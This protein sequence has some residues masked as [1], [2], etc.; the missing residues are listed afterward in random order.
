MQNPCY[1]NFCIYFSVKDYI[2][3]CSKSK[4]SFFYSFIILTYAR[5]FCN[6]FAVFDQHFV[7]QI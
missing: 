5:L 1:F 6:L 4:Q 2:P 7:I 3:S